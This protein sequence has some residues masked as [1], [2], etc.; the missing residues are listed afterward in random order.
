MEQDRA[1][2]VKWSSTLQSNEAKYSFLSLLLYHIQVQSIKCCWYDL[3]MK[4]GSKPEIDEVIHN[5]DGANHVKQSSTLQSSQVK[6]SI[7]YFSLIQF[8]HIDRGNY[9]MGGAKYDID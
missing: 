4:D 3:P 8:N 5:I 9:E 6:S 7:G 1:N 2:R